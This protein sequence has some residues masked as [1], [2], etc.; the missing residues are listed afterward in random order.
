[1]NDA[2]YVV[3]SERM[4]DRLQTIKECDLVSIIKEIADGETVNLDAVM[5][6]IEWLIKRVEQLE[7]EINFINQMPF[8]KVIEELRGK[9]ERS[10]I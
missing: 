2:K 10:F 1:V 7:K 3:R 9:A 4:N 5:D 8:I 6:D